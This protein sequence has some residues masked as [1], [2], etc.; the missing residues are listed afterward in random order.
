MDVTSTLA[1]SGGIMSAKG[2]CSL[3]LG[4]VED[5]EGE[6]AS[7]A[8]QTKRKKKKKKK[9]IGRMKCQSNSCIVHPT[10]HQPIFIT[11]Q[12]SMSLNCCIC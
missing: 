5:G 4:L 1:S 2:V 12:S 6:E 7:S 11:L 9:G 8:K 3:L 10:K